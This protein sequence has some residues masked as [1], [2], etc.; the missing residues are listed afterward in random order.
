[1]LIHSDQKPFQCDECDQA[2]RQKQ[3]L[4]R[5]KNL[6]HNP[7]YVPPTPKEKTHECPEC[8]KAFRHKGNLIRHLAV[9][10]PDATAQEKEE[11]MRI[12]QPKLPG[13][14]KDGEEDDYDELMDDPDE[15]FSDEDDDDDDDED[16]VM[17]EVETNNVLGTNAD[18]VVTVSG[19]QVAQQGGQGTA[20]V[21]QPQATTGQNQ[22]VVLEVIQVS[23]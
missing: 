22:V 10:D 5:H 6:Y 17:D 19:H 2:F 23:R 12:G 1:M 8:N 16:E 9:H 14:K 18:G 15:E 7:N 13:E 11:A 4:K 20:Q 21:G 3:L